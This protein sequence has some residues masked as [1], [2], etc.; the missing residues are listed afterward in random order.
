MKKCKVILEIM[1][2]QGRVV[3]EIKQ[4][5][6][7]NGYRYGPIQWDGKS[8]SGAKLKC[9]NVCLFSYCKSFKWKNN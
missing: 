2:L 1:D 3:K 6:T 5:I 9:R 8:E 4:N 7:P